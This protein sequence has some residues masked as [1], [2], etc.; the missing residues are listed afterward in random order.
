[1][2]SESLA[3]E[4]EKGPLYEKAGPIVNKVRIV[5]RESES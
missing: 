4:S 3:V 1:M 2:C 5:R